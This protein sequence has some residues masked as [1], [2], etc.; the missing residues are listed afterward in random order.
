MTNQTSTI[1]DIGGWSAVLGNLTDG[2]DLSAADARIAMIEI[3]RGDAAESQIAGLLV[4]LK[5]KGET[6]GELTGL[7]TAMMDAAEPLSVPDGAIDIVGTGGSSHRRQH[8]LNVSTMAC[9]VASS[10]GAVVCKH[11]NRKASSTSGS[12]DF[13]EALGVAIELG[14]ANL[15]A[16]VEEVGLGFA[17]ARTFHPAMRFAGPVRAA[18]GIPTVFNL[19]GPLANPGRVTRQVVGV[20][21][22]A[23]AKQMAE[24]LAEL[25]STSSWV[26]S[27]HGGLDELSIAGDNTVFAVSEGGVAQHDMTLASVG[28]SPVGLDALV[29][30]DAAANVTVFERIL[31]GETGPYRDIVLLNAGAGLVVGGH[32]ETL[33]EA[34]A[35][36]GAAVD[37]GRTKAK[38]DQLRTVTNRL[39][40]AGT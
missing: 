40:G 14:S 2:N 3:L 12:F 6:V 34:M 5:A 7:A 38:I 13:L 9:I 27:G 19:L 36:A 15:E 16:C 29:G 10:A 20:S 11:G 31:A 8:A 30:G 22:P 23:L 28:I 17:F 18:L 32:A 25:G 37:D 24:A 26:V 21:S 39:V 33:P 1:A 4:G 35:M